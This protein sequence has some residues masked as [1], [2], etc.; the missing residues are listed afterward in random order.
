MLLKNLVF[1]NYFD[2]QVTFCYMSTIMM[3]VYKLSLGL[4]NIPSVWLTLWYPANTL[5]SKKNT[6]RITSGFLLCMVR[7][8][9][10]EWYGTISN[11]CTVAVL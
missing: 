2:M 3:H 4:T 7:Y 10:I 11:V 5:Y 9:V 1:V 6:I 8:E